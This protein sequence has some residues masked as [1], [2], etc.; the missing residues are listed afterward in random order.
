MGFARC[1]AKTSVAPLYIDTDDIH[2]YSDIYWAW[3]SNIHKTS[4]NIKK[5]RQNKINHLGSDDS[6]KHLI[7]TSD[8]LFTETV[9]KSTAS[10]ISTLRTA[11]MF[12]GEIYAS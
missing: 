11:M 5:Q 2:T 3:T 1:L 7:F 12:A 10:E 6:F 4:L 9:A 8:M